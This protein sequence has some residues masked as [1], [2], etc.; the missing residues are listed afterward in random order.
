MRPTYSLFRFFAGLAACGIGMPLALATNQTVVPHPVYPV[1]RGPGEFGHQV[2]YLRNGNFVVVDPAA[3][4]LFCGKVGAVH[5]YSWDG[6]PI[7]SLWGGDNCNADEIGSA[8][9]LALDTGHFVV[10][11]PKW[12]EGRGAATWI[13]GVNGRPSAPLPIPDPGYDLVASGNS[14]VGSTIGDRVG[15][16]AVSI[17]GRYVVISREHGQLRGAVTWC[18]AV[19]GP[20]G[21]VSAANSIV[22]TRP[23]DF[24]G[25]R[26]IPLR[27]G[28]YVVASPLWDLSDTV[29]DV[30][31]VTW[32]PP[33]QSCRGT[34]DSTRSLVGARTG[35][36]IGVDVVALS[37]G[38]YVVHSPA[39]T[40]PADILTV[41]VGAVT[42][43]NG[44]TGTVGTVGA[45][46]SLT[47]RVHGDLLHSRVVPLTNGNYVVA[48]PS[49]NSSS[50]DA[51]AV[52]WA[53]GSL[54]TTGEISPSNALRG[55]LAGDGDDLQVVALSNGNYV[56]GFSAWDRPNGSGGFIENV[57]AAVWGNGNGGGAVEISLN[58]ALVGTRTGD[59]VGLAI[60]ALS[61]GN[62][63]VQSPYWSNGS[64]EAV[65]AATWRSGAGPQPNVV[66]PTNSVIG[67]NPGDYVGTY[68]TALS[69]GHYVVGSPYW[70]ETRGAI[71]RVA[72]DG[73]AAFVVAA[74]NSLV[75]QTAGHYVGTVGTQLTAG[76]KRNG[77]VALTNGNYVVAS[78]HLF[79]A[80]GALTWQRGTATSAVPGG[81]IGALNSL[82]GRTANE[83]VGEE[84]GA[85]LTLEALPKGRY[86]ASAPLFGPQDTGAVVL[87]RSDGGP[88]GV[89]GV[90]PALDVVEGQTVGGGARMTWSYHA[91]VGSLVVG[92][93]ASNRVTLLNRPDEIFRADLDG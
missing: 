89:L 50:A 18:P 12:H 38:N 72:G 7:R 80:A 73:P 85:A 3:V 71:T 86:V 66:T 35:D 59:R 90:T 28:A 45:G 74:A 9:I 52:M 53:N 34:L 14:L 88:I 63:V 75:G 48:A 6:T 27:N 39:W 17:G 56:A 30:G 2:T 5:L 25:S 82:V 87:A 61:N 62:F 4:D 29:T 33:L 46:N 64:A 21:E 23:G 69:N 1:D 65:G 13:N 57:G 76:N 37:N 32:C 79:N 8:G 47:G 36:Q 51:G 41:D 11:S 58:N 67:A 93:P 10:L 16:E 92:D 83:P 84:D 24:F 81:E 91:G 19:G 43:G 78:A 22:G 49:W 77:V 68:V 44:V 31:A 70:N 54:V 42:W 20:T 60:T 15:A 26:V 40:R 55:S